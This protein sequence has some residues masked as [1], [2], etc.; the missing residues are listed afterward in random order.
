MARV[1]VEDCTKIV[2]NRFDLVLLAAQRAREIA[3]G[4]AIKVSR[5][6]DKN[7]VIALREIAG[8]KVSL[9][10]L[11]QGIIKGLQK[12]AEPE[13]AEEEIL[14][15][16]AEEQNWVQNTENQSMQEEMQ[17]DHLHFEDEAD[18]SDEPAFTV[19]D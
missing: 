3:G 13:E 9:E 6:N 8:E 17:E 1:T 10:T 12:V 5:D 18:L 16:M 4:S 7:P 2:P 15:V 19:A 14:R 11:C